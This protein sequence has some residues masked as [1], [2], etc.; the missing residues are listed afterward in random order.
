M[1]HLLWLGHLMPGFTFC[2]GVF[3]A[4]A[5]SS[6]LHVVLALALVANG[7]WMAHDAHER[8]LL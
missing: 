1:K 4:A 6:W 5:A 2:L 8:R 7:L 3:I